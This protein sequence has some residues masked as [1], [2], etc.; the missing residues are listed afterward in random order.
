MPLYAYTALGQ[1]GRK[2]RSFEVADD[3]GSLERRLKAR[4]LVLIKC[5]ET[6]PPSVAYPVQVE[7]VSQLANLVDSGI[8]VERA[9]Q[10][11]GEDAEDKRTGALAGRLRQGLKRGQSLSQALEE[12]GRFDSL[13]VPLVRAGEASG[14]LGPVLK[15]LEE[16]YERK[17]RLQREIF[18]TLA[19]PVVLAFASIASLIGLGVYVV[20]IFEDLFAES[21][22]ALPAS[23]RAIFAMSD[24]LLEYGFVLAF[25]LATV[26]L[27]L[28][29]AYQLSNPVRFAVHGTILRLPGIGPF[30]VKLDTAN[31]T[32]VLGVLLGNGVSLAPAL[33]IAASAAINLHVRRGWVEA[34]GEVRRGRRLAVACERIPKFPA[35]ARRLISAG[36]GTGRLDAMCARAG[37]LLQEDIQG[38]IKTAVALIEPAIILALG[39][40]VGFVVISMLLAVFSLSDLG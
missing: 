6:R 19:Y 28:A 4:R 35:L 39:G 27:G 18:G 12:I 24:V 15:T 31:V 9:L 22:V 38:R 37:R 17:R 14:Q 20:P 25:G 1:D 36:E 10:A 8:V 33:E 29:L 13:L 30:L 21:T 16:H 11:V 3:R 23:T 5:R 2:T 26:V 7:L 34:L 32:A 40:A